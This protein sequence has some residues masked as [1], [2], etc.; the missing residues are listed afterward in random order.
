MCCILGCAH[1]KRSALWQLDLELKIF[2]EMRIYIDSCVFQGF[3]R[4]DFSDLFIAI[5]EDKLKNLYCFSEAHLYD[6]ARDTSDEKFTDMKFIEDIVENNCYYYNKKISFDHF[7]PT[8]YYNLYD[9]DNVTSFFFDDNIFADTFKSIFKSI[10]LNFRDFIQDDQIPE[11]FPPAFMELLLGTTT[12][13][14]FFHRFLSFTAELT[15]EQKKFKEFIRYLHKSSLTTNIYETIGIKGFDGTK[16]IDKQLF[17]ET[18]SEHFLKNAKEKYRYDL[19][20]DMYNGLEI[21]G[22]VKGKP[23]KQKMMNLINDGRHAFFGAFCDIMVSTDEDFLY[24]TRFIYDFSDIETLVLKPEEFQDIIQNSKPETHSLAGLL[25]ELKEIKKK[26]IVSKWEDDGK[27][28]SLVELNNKYY[29]YFDIIIFVNEKGKFC[30]FF[31][32]KIN[33][34]STGTITKEIKYVINKLVS[35]LGK[36]LDQKGDFEICEIKDDMW[37]G[38]NW[39]FA[40]TLIE[41]NISSKMYLRFYTLT[42]ES[43]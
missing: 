36:D 12:V 25:S 27:E 9:W 42:N 10:P 3:K 19:F 15:S 40:D 26:G 20:I 5:K 4:G 18:Y 13:Y 39:I 37:C 30:H 22:F 35:E 11:G 8:E 14:D 23:K 31:S 43:E 16:V 6:L 21:F 7:T 24:K 33:N 17:R 38:R 34:F 28:Y 1:Y 41:L 32:K 29:G 2:E